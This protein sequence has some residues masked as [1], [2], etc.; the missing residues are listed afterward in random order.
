[1]DA[2]ALFCP[3]DVIHGDGQGL[4]AA[5]GAIVDQ[6]EQGAIARIVDGA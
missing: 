1:V 3:V 4:A 5:Q 2:A 6:P